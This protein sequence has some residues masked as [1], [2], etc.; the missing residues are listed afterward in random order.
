METTQKK[1]WPGRR[2][3]S[4]GALRLALCAL[5]VSVL[6]LP[7]GA[8]PCLRD[9][10]WLLDTRTLDFAGAEAKIAIE[11]PNVFHALRFKIAGGPVAVK[12]LRVE[13]ADG[14]MSPATELVVRNG[15]WSDPV[16]FPGDSHHLV[17]SLTVSVKPMAGQSGATL[18]IFGQQTV[19]VKPS[20]C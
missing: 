2:M 9:E 14:A 10:M 19:A 5:A 13:F 11:S 20:G 16:P 7:A 4:S 8:A 6:P 12:V 15:L 18:E 1:A 3:I 17:K